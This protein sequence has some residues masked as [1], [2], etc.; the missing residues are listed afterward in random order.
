MV[1]GS[2]HCQGDTLTRQRFPTQAHSSREGV[3]PLIGGLPVRRVTNARPKQ[4]PC[5]FLGRFA[6]NDSLDYQLPNMSNRIT[7]RCSMSISMH[8]AART[9]HTTENPLPFAV[10]CHV[11]STHAQ[12]CRRSMH[13]PVR[14]HKHDQSSIRLCLQRRDFPEARL[15]LPSSCQLATGLTNSADHAARDVLRG[16][17]EVTAAALAPGKLKDSGLCRR[18]G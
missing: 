15:S 18:A 3:S 13:R 16:G 1:S 11:Q 12:P 10:I 14:R 6:R 4:K 9:T 5:D 7:K 2:P 8:I 17:N